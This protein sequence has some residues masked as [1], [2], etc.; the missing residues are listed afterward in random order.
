MTASFDFM[1]QVPTVRSPSVAAC[2]RNEVQ[3]W[4]EQYRIFTHK[5]PDDWMALSMDECRH[6]LREYNLTEEQKTDGVILMASYCRLLDEAGLIHFGD[7]EHEAC[8]L[9]VERLTP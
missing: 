7:T 6:L 2:R 8:R 5:G 4:R 3:A 9:L 1:R